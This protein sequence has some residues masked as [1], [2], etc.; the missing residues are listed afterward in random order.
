MKKFD[1]L[2]WICNPFQDNLPTSMSTKASEELIDL[3]EDTLLKNSFNRKQLTK[4][5]LSVADNYPCLFDEAMK[6]LL[7]FTTSCLNTDLNSI[8]QTHCD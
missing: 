6:V 3:S 8:Y 1:S 7:L 2:S 4:F 5:W